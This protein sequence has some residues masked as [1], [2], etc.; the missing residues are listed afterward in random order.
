[1]P[2]EDTQEKGHKYPFNACEILCSMN[3]L[4]IEK[5][6]EVT[7]T[8]NKEKSEDN[9]SDSSINNNQD[10]EEKIENEDN[11]ENSKPDTNYLF[12]ILDYFFTFLEYEDSIN[13]SVL[14][15]YFNKIATYLIKNKPV[16]ILNYYFSIR[17]DIISKIIKYI[18]KNSMANTLLIILSALCATDTIENSTEHFI[19]VINQL[20]DSMATNDASI[21]TICELLINAVIYNNNVYLVKIIEISIIDKFPEIIK[22]N[23]TQEKNNKNILTPIMSFLT[24]MNNSILGNFPKKLTETL[25]PDDSKIEIYNLL[26]LCDRS[27][28]LFINFNI[29]TLTSSEFLKNYENSFDHFCLGLKN[30][31]LLISNDL[32]SNKD[33]IKKVGIEQITKFEFIIS[34]IDLY[35]NTIGTFLENP[36]IELI[37]NYLIEISNTRIFSLMIEYYFKFKSNNIFQNI[38]VQ[39]MKIIRNENTP[40]KLISNII[41]SN[42]EVNNLISLLINDLVKN[43]KYTFS[44][45]ENQS[46]S[47]L[48]GSNVTILNYIFTSKNKYIINILSLL[49][50]SKFF[51]DKFITNVSELF[52]KKLFK[53]SNDNNSNTN[54]ML[55]PS[56]PRYESV[57]NQSPTELSFSLFTLNE[58]I[59]LYLNVYDKY[60]KGEDYNDLITEHIELLKKRRN[61]DEYLHLAHSEEEKEE[62]EEGDFE[63]IPTPNFFNSR[64]ESQKEN[65]NGK[66]E[67]N[68][69]KKEEN[70]N[71]NEK[72][73]E[74]KDIKN[75]NKEYNDINY[76]HIEFN[77]SQLDNILSEL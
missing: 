57:N 25:N 38:F 21:E 76:W 59:Q 9:N 10:K 33:N 5:L 60:I 62:S 19:S 58:I 73:E 46:N 28:S 74:N 67:E 8:D 56:D 14:L 17:K 2:L 72:N 39:L 64:I 66:N 26:K 36:N 54:E 23:L 11:D 27:N 24:K 31:C 16:I 42:N 7:K 13:N 77:N 52:S 61:S 37:E 35:I 51:Y 43:T 63:D 12:E 69:D 55:D 53:L 15:G 47:L 65:N 48:F 22:K 3:G 30:I 32:V 44:N 75:E 49:P 29:K 70:E 41:S 34:V 71:K 1:M 4:N 18:N 6:S 40:E 45:T 20:F 50:K 68:E